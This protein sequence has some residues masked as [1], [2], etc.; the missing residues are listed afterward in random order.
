[1]GEDSSVICDG[2]NVYQYTP[3]M[4]LIDH[5]IIFD[6]CVYIYTCYGDLPDYL[7]TCELYNIMHTKLLRKLKYFQGPKDLSLQ[8]NVNNFGCA[9]INCVSNYYDKVL[10]HTVAFH[11]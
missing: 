3:A 4:Q 6:W 11:L 10:L 9:C 5:Y 1:M 2:I 8:I 7:L